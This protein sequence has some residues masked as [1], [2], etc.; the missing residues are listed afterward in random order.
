MKVQ[1]DIRLVVQVAKMYY[2]EG[3]TQE[4]I[5]RELHISR[6]AISVILSAARELGIVE[7]KIKDPMNNVES[8]AKQFVNMFGLKD[9]LVVPTAINGAKLVT[10]VVA[11]QGADFIRDLMENNFVIG[12]AWGETCYECMMS[13][14]NGKDLRNST[15]VPLMG[16]AP[17]VAPEYQ[18]NEMARK[19]AEKLQ[20]T[21][22]FIYA[23][24][25]AKSIEDAEL[26]SKSTEMKLMLDYWTRMDMAI[27]SVGAPL[28]R[29]DEGAESDIRRL[30]NICEADKN[31][32]V[33]DI[34]SRQINIHGE[35][36]DSDH[37]RRVLGV[38]EEELRATK[39][40]VCIVAG[41]HK[42]ISIIGALRTG[43]IDYLVTDETTARTVLELLES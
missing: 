22:S 40:A 13:F 17:R 31:R 25:I 39:R 16:G 7:I 9:C 10:K 21:P 42:V 18:A 8:L 37:N 4:K 14:T 29:F 24:A 35:F 12:I 19:F 34:C 32:T 11:S 36:P 2:S 3:L 41:Q 20:G 5:A 23:P 26:F 33:G 38:G 1:H 27:F 15:V 28:E 6:S 30:K 43:T